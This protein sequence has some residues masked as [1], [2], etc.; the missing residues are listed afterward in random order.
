MLI[1]VLGKKN[2]D[3]DKGG[4]RDEFEGDKKGNRLQQ[5]LILQAKKFKKSVYPG[6]IHEFWSPD[7]KFIGIET[8]D[9]YVIYR[10]E[11]GSIVARLD[12]S[13]FAPAL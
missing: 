6:L 2:E 7:S 4:A 5:N 10:T 11:D 3:K 13:Y 12:R 1:D 8:V 9:G